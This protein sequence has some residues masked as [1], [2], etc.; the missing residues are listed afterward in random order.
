MI[1]HFF[2]ALSPML[3]LLIQDQLALETLDAIRLS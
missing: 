1:E 3:L 2:L